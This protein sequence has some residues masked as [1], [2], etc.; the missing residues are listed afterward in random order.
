MK[1]ITIIIDGKEISAQ[2]DDAVRQKLLQPVTKET[3]Y[4]RVEKDKQYFYVDSDG[5]I[6]SYIDDG[7]DGDNSTDKELY[8]LANYYSNEAVAETTPEPTN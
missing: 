4:E 8:E 7:D 6:E 3:G 5:M 1:E 2:I